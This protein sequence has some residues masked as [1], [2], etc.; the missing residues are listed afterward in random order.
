MFHEGYCSPRMTSEVTC[1]AFE[2]K[3]LLL[4]LCSSTDS[5]LLI[6]YDRV[7]ADMVFRRKEKLMQHVG[8]L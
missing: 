2:H 7:M 1:L 5:I 4:L 6:P 3:N 8:V